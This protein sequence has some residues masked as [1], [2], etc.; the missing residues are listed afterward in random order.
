[1]SPF[2][3]FK[4]VLVKY[5]V[6]EYKKGSVELIVESAEKYLDDTLSEEVMTIADQLRAEGMQK[7]EKAAARKIAR[8]L[9]KKGVSLDLIAESTGLSLSE[10]Q[11]LKTDPSS[12]TQ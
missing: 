7:G 12:K 9:F 10:L 5:I 6:S 8:N 4:S 11:S 3:V 2:T 1:L